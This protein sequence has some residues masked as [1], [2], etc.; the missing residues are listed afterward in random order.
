MAYELIKAFKGEKQGEHQFGFLYGLM[1][2]ALDEPD[3]IRVYNSRGTYYTAE[4]LRDAFVDGVAE[5]RTK[6]KETELRNAIRLMVASSMV[7]SG[8]GA[9]AAAHQVI[10]DID[11]KWH[12]T[13]SRNQLDWPTP[14]PYTGGLIGLLSNQ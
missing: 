8:L 7:G 4:E 6:G 9:W 5:G 14:F 1:W 12:K 2:Q 11:D 10:T 3:H 13:K